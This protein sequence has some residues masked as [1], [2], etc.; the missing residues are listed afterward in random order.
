MGFSSVCVEPDLDAIG[1]VQADEERA[2]A[3]AGDDPA[4]RLACLVEPGFPRVH[5]VP[6]GHEKGEGVEPGQGF[7]PIRVVP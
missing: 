7:G 1:V 5:V 2:P 3:V 4:V 6:R